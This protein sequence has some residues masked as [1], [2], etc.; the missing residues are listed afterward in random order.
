VNADPGKLPFAIA[1]DVGKHLVVAEAGASSVATFTIRPDGTLTLVDR[2]ATGQNGTCWIAA[3]GSLFYASNAG[4][5]TLSG[6]KDFGNGTLKLLGMAAT[7][8]GT[9]DSTATP[10]GHYL[11]AQTGANGSW[12]STAS[13][14]AGR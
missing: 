8:P 7:D 1:F 12:T 6:Y 13:G 5:G 9:V 11:Y 10:D 14:P 2:Q 4:S 3:D